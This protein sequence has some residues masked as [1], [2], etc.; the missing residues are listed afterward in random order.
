M[1]HWIGEAEKYRWGLNISNYKQPHYLFVLRLW[2]LCTIVVELNRDYYRVNGVP[3][4]YRRHISIIIY[5]G[6]YQ[7]YHRC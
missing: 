1:I 4:K 5:P 3:T 2:P 7:T 6:R